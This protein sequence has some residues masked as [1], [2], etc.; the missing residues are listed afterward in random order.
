MIKALVV[1]VGLL[2]AA[3]G[4]WFTALQNEQYSKFNVLILWASPFIAA[5]LSAYLAPRN[6]LLLG[7]SMVLPTAILSV[8]LN[9]L[10]QAQ[11]NLVDFPGSRGALILFMT[12]LLYSSILCGVG[13][14]IGRALFNKKEK[15]GGLRRTVEK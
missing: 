2:I 3:Y 10:Y 8:A 12:T 5:L 4:L 6:K 9:Y 11:G 7:I 13:A 1:G 14:V 15:H